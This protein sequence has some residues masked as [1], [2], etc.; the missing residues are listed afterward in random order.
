MDRGSQESAVVAA[1]LAALRLEQGRV[2]TAF[3]HAS[4]AAAVFLELSLPVCARWC[5][6]LSAHALALAGAAPRPTGRSPSST[7]W[8]SH[9]HA[10]RSGGA[11]GLS[12]GL[13]GR[14]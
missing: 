9:R 5:E 4:S 6:A 8:D 3:L 11:G 10:V 13:G 7:P 2:Q 1:S 14:W 12:L